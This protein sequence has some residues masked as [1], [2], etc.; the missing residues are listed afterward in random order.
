[1]TRF[2]KQPRWQAGLAQQADRKSRFAG[3]GWTDE[4]QILIP[5]QELEACQ[6]M[7]LRRI[8]SRLAG[9]GKGLERPAPR[10]LGVMQTVRQ[11][12]LAPIRGFFAEEPLEELRAASG[13][14]LGGFDLRFLLTG[15]VPT[16]LAQEVSQP[17]LAEGRRCRH[18]FA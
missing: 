10:Q 7:D 4:Q 11:A 15:V 14:A 16:I 1:M 3:A 8:D 13:F 5:T 9:E 6:R 17:R 12:S 18:R 2:T